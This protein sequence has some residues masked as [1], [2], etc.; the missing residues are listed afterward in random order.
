MN[1]IRK[2]KLR[3]M[4]AANTLARRHLRAVD[5][6]EEITLPAAPNPLRTSARA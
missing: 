6:H 1:R 5:V 4:H 2:G 3:G